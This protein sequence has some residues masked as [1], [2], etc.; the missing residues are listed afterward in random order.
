MFFVASK[1]IGFFAIPSNLIV[2]IGILGLLL[3]PTR[4]GRAGRRLVVA[5]L[6]LLAVLGLSPVGNALI[7][8]VA[9]RFPP[10]DAAGGAPAG[11][12]V[13]GGSL[14]PH[15]SAGRNEVA[16]NEGAERLTVAA[17]LAL[18]YPD[19]R[20]LFSGGSGALIFEEGA[21][22]EF[23]IRVFESF[24]IPRARDARGSLTQHGRKRNL[25]QE[26]RSAEA[27]RALAVGD[28][29]LPHAAVDRH[30]S[31]GRLCGRSLPGRLAYERCR[32]CAASVSDRR[33]RPAADRH[34]GTR[35]G[36]ALGLLADGQK[37][38]A[39]SGSDSAPLKK[40]HCQRLGCF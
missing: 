12:V 23:A 4:F 24:G 28:V 16:L 21:E 34:G 13:L 7:L 35:M 33:R 27:R 15:V 19:A 38:G 29:R 9:P 5:S 20:I 30:L 8:P 31:S 10:W 25:F 2:S 18:R 6:V 37:L 39:F 11:I 36:R 3:W 1:V 26:S 40:Y 22:A 14:S 32:G 17:E